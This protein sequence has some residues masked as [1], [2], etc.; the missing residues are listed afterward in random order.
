VVKCPVKDCPLW[1]YR[2][3]R[4]IST[5]CTECPG[6]NLATDKSGVSEMIPRL[7]GLDAPKKKIVAY[8]AS[9]GLK[10]RRAEG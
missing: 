3:G 4:K 8:R 1:P 6:R 9:E 5:G 2:L 7:E 10:N